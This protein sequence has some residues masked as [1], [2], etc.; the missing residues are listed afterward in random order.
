[1]RLETQYIE[2]WRD[3]EV[4][5]AVLE[6]IEFFEKPHPESR[7]IQQSLEELTLLKMWLEGRKFDNF[8]EIGRSDGGSL[9]VYTRL[10]CN[11][12]ARVCTLDYDHR[13]VADKVV[14]KLNEFGYKVE[15]HGPSTEFIH[16]VPD[17]SIDLLHI[18]GDHNYYGV[19]W[20]FYN[21][22]SKVI[23]GGIITLHDTAAH[24]DCIRF[25]GELEYTPHKW[26]MRTF[27]GKYL[28][29]ASINDLYPCTGIT[30]VV[31]H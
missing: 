15:K 16:S 28:V 11:K 6:Y 5:N 25:R 10:F 23:P 3:K 19:S 4:A 31:K 27:V 7:H 2:N 24:P 14:E 22:Y 29:T 1:M 8:V 18:D 21:Y 13:I 30:A 17:N 26:D 20:D 12:G 9:W